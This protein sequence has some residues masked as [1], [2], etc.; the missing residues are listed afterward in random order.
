MLDVDDVLKQS[1]HKHLS[2]LA[3]MSELTLFLI[4]FDELMIGRSKLFLI[5][6]EWAGL[7]SNKHIKMLSGKGPRLCERDM[8][9][10]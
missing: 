9:V 7:S 10:N 8:R 4:R 1:E 2:I 6:K 3:T 5:F